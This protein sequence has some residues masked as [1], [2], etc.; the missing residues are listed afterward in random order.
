MLTRYFSDDDDEISDTDSVFHAHDRVAT[1]Y[2]KDVQKFRAAH[3]GQPLKHKGKQLLLGKRRGGLKGPRKI[4]ELPGDIRERLA[5]ATHHFMRKNYTEAREEAQDIIKINGEVYQAYSLLA[6]I[7]REWGHFDD[8]LLA[9]TSCAHFMPK[10]EQGTAWLDLAR[11]IDEATPEDREKNLETGVYCCSE[12]LKTLRHNVEGLCLKASFQRG[13]NRIGKATGDYE[14][15]LKVDPHNPRAMRGLA[16]CYLDNE[17]PELAKKLYQDAITFYQESDTSKNRFGW[18][19]LAIF[20]E[21]HASSGEYEEAIKNLKSL[22]RWILGRKDESYWDE[23]TEDDREWDADD[24]R[25][26][27]VAQY[28]PDK[29]DMLTYGD[30]LPLE[31]RTKLGVYRIKLGDSHFKEAMVSLT[32]LTSS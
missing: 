9:S 32:I 11:R 28:E 26:N 17:Q 15:A 5:R 3:S 12:A 27:E 31:L 7:F 10:E 18:N 24:L 6:S 30:G 20:L 1:R 8:E 21:L 19:E 23:V 2:K 25:R 22:S 14:H 4:A 29:Y 13:C 16:E